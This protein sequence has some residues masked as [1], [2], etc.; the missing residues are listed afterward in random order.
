MLRPSTHRQRRTLLGALLAIALLVAVAGPAAADPPSRPAPSPAF[1]PDAR[2]GG[3]SRLS[4]AL[5]DFRW[6]VGTGGAQSPI[7]N[8]DACLTRDDDRVGFLPP[9]VDVGEVSH[10]RASAG[11]A[12]LVSPAVTFC[13]DQDKEPGQTLAECAASGWPPL[14]VEVTVDGVKVPQIEAYALR[15]TLPITIAP[16]NPFYAAGRTNAAFN[17]VF[18]VLKPLRPG[19]HVVTQFADFD[20]VTTFSST[21]Y[22]DV[23]KD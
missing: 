7:L 23:R 13:S 11:Q 19:T 5:R 2:V 21:T 17:G 14:R 15:A 16:D 10:C 20:G 22:V 3:E 1:A 18:V 8:P 12:L 9:P 6:V 4:V